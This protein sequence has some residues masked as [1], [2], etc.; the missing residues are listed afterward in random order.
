MVG[1]SS[2]VTQVGSMEWWTGIAD[3]S[4]NSVANGYL[5]ILQDNDKLLRIG[6]KP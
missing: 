3:G 2:Y 5:H 1:V 6:L 4:S